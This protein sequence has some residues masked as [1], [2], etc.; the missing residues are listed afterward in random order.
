MSKRRIKNRVDL[1]GKKNEIFRGDLTQVNVIAGKDAYYAI[2]VTAQKLWPDTLYRS[3]T[4]CHWSTANNTS[5]LVESAPRQGAFCLMTTAIRQA[6]EKGRGQGR[7]VLP[8]RED[9]LFLQQRSN[10]AFIGSL[11]YSLDCWLET[12]YFLIPWQTQ[13]S[14]QTQSRGW[15]RKSVAPYSQNRRNSLSDIWTIS[16]SGTEK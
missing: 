9:L 6:A 14:Q 1:I 3:S 8:V 13:K 4:S 2:M 5:S 10:R 11:K 15:R 16:P 12:A 7:R